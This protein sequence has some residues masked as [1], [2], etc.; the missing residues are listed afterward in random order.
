[1]LKYY[2]VRISHHGLKSILKHH[3]RMKVNFLDIFTE[4]DE[5]DLTFL[6]DNITII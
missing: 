5:Q 6:L 2:R 1:M 4:Y 3:G